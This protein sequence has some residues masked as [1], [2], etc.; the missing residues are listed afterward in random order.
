[1]SPLSSARGYGRDED[2][3][4]ARLPWRYAVPVI[5]ALSV[6]GWTVIIVIAAAVWHA[7]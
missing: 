3:V 5:V 1:M 2:S 6:L 4:D 7:I